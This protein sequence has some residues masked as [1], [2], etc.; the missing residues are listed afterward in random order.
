MSHA[1]TLHPQYLTDADGARVAVV[2]PLAEF[3][4]LMED[5]AQLRRTAVNGDVP[6]PDADAGR[7]RQL[8]AALEAAARLDPF[9]GQDGAQWQHQQRADRPLPGRAE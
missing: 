4:A 9:A 6:G 8:A 2:L 3:E 1:D 5:I 7:S